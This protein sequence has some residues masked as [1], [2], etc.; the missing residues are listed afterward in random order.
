[1]MKLTP[2]KALKE[3]G[4]LKENGC[5]IK[6][7]VEYKIV[8]TALKDSEWY[9][10]EMIKF[11]KAFTKENEEKLKLQKVLEIIKKELNLEVKED[12]GLYRLITYQTD[13]HLVR[14]DQ[15]DLLKEVLH[16]SKL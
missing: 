15:Y 3:I 12:N 10:N 1:M 5:Y 4:L 8:E 11:E 2:S 6:S 13:N 7:T 16:E 14:K 9:K